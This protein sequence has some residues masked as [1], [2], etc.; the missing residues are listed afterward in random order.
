M[1]GCKIFAVLF[2]PQNLLMDH[3]Y[4]VN[5]CLQSFYISFSLLPGIESQV[6]L[7]VDVKI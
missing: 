4:K 3:G 5:E 2:N 6:L 1:F 7:T